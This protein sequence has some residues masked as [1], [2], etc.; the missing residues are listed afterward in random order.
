MQQKFWNVIS[1]V[2]FLTVLIWLIFSG[3]SGYRKDQELKSVERYNDCLNFAKNA[4]QRSYCENIKPFT[5][6]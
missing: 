2:I 4:Q 6:K 1:V 3:T 5:L